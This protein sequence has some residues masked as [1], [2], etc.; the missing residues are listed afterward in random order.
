[1]LLIT[2]FVEL[3][4]VA[5]RSQKR[6]G[7]PQAVFRRPCCAV[8]LRRKAWSEHGMASVNQTGPHCAN[9]MGKTH[10]KP[11][12]ARHGRGTA[13]ARYAMYGSAFNRPTVPQTFKEFYA[14]YGNRRLITKFTTAHHVYLS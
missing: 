7:S 13:R 14:L 8:A 9:Q 5:G 4:V 1:M 10:C 12:A 2:V 11:L 6:A 3:R